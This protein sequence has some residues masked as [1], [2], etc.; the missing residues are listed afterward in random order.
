MGV[1]SKPKV[2]DDPPEPILPVAEDVGEDKSL[3]AARARRR[4]MSRLAAGRASTIRT[5]PGGLP[6]RSPSTLTNLLG[7]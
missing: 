7:S 6:S 4:V 3:A 5:S 2:P 1:F